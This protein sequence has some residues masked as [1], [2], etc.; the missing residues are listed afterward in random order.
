M[1]G[2]GDEA[3]DGVASLVTGK[4]QQNPTEAALIGMGYAPSEAKVI[5]GWINTGATLVEMAAGGVGV[6]KAGKMIG[7]LDN[8][9]TGKPSFVKFDAPLD[10]KRPAPELDAGLR[11][12][13]GAVHPGRPVGVG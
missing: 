9:P 6:F 7:Y 11:P 4:A 10:G 2:S 13:D 5:H 12:D 1:I 3:Y 8:A